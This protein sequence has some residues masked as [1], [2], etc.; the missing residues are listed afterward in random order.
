MRLTPK[1]ASSK[2]NE[3]YFYHNISDKRNKIKPKYE[4]NNIVRVA[5]LK[6]IFSQGDTTNWSYILYQVTEF[7][8]DTKP[9]YKIDN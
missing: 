7:I 4:V 9:R 8:D 2:K 3:G 1:Q 5:D 6:R